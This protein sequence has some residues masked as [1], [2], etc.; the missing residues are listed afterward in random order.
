MTSEQEGGREKEIAFCLLISGLIDVRY[1]RGWGGVSPTL[2]RSSL[3]LS[4]SPFCL[5]ISKQA[6]LL[7]V[8]GAVAEGQQRGEGVCSH[9]IQ[10]SVEGKIGRAIYIYI[11]A[12]IFG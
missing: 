10:L 5:S 9:S 3:S 8:S 4:L 11:M 12:G 6:L 1:K 2:K 7:Y